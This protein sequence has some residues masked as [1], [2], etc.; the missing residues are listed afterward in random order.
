MRKPPMSLY[1]DYKQVFIPP[2]AVE[3]LERGE[4][5]SV[6]YDQERGVMAIF[7][8]ASALVGAVL[9]Y[10]QGVPLEIGVIAGCAGMYVFYL[11]PT[12]IG[13]ENLAHPLRAILVALIAIMATI[14]LAI[15]L[16]G[17]GVTLSALKIMFIAPVL[18]L[19]VL[20]LLVLVVM[21]RDA[22]TT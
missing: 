18:L 11:L 3:R 16:G 19:V 21:I 4:I 9:A 6:K 5:V 7:G 20:L 22:H 10:L 14:A 2:E 1:V 15:M 12:I 8:F 13:A 17:N